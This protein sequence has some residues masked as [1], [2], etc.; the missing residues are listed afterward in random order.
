MSEVYLTMTTTYENKKLCID[1]HPSETANDGG[2]EW[3]V[4]SRKK[5][6]KKCVD[7]KRKEAFSWMIP[8]PSKI[9][10][11]IP[12]NY[13]TPFYF[14]DKHTMPIKAAGMILYK[15]ENGKLFLLMPSRNDSDEDP[16]Y[17]DIGGQ[18]DPKD[19]N[20]LSTI[21]REVGEETN[22]VIKGDLL[23]KDRL[24]KAKH[25]YIRHGKYL[26]SVMSA[27][28][29]ESELRPEEFGDAEN[30]TERKRSISWISYND[31]MRAKYLHIRLFNKECL[32]FLKKLST[33]FK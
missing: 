22:E 13:Y 27:T 24:E 33:G 16:I 21:C 9:D 5:R 4:V 30:T 19:Q 15:Y 14:K 18:I 1:G 20:Y 28:K 32:A 25:I 7:H 17:E 23:L 12:R 26:L 10:H 6:A 11:R 29:E 3:V 8:D 31:V 2:D